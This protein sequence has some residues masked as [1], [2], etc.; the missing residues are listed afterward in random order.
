MAPTPFADLNSVL[1]TFVTKV[2]Q[3]LGDR[4]VGA[5]LQGSFAIGDFD[6]HSDVDFL[7]AIAD[8]LRPP[9]LAALQALHA[10]LFTLPSPWAQH[11]EGSYFPLAVL[12]DEA[13][14]GQP[15]YYLDNTSSVLVRSNHDNTLVVRWMTREQGIV[16]AGPAPKRLIAP[17]DSEA[18]R[19]EIR[20][21]MRDWGGEILANPTRISNR[22]YQPFVV[23]SYCRMLHS[24][25]TGTIQ[26][27]LAG[28]RWAQD[29]LSTRW[30]DLIERAW[31][32]RP[33]PSAKIRQPADPAEVALTLAFVQE[34]I[35]AL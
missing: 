21:V 24:L 11:L 19:S 20:A 3:A 30:Y 6:E 18:L 12:R 14:V 35:S 1:Q 16:L 28:A 13:Q 17:V 9:E 25:Q 23:L 22:W 33:D 4:F 29:S 8:E 26:S 15:L 32:E 2:G 5:Y 27:K 31:A 10:E 7:V 34:A